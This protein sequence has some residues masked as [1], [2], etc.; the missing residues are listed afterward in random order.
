M[1]LD[2]LRPITW[3]SRK[4][5]DAML[6]SQAENRRYLSGFTGSAGLLLISAGTRP[7]WPPISAT[8]SRW[9]ARL[10][11]FH[12][13]KIQ[14]KVS[15]ICCPELVGRHRASGGWVSRAST[16]PWTSSISGA[17]ATDNVE[18]VPLR[19]RPWRRLR[20]VKDERPS[21]RRLRQ[22]CGVDRCC[23]SPICSEVLDAGHDGGGCSRLG[24]RG[25]HAHP[26]RDQSGL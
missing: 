26:R 22:L 23:L 9:G 3:Q 6:V 1:R 10:L 13:A 15:R 12:L 14:T 19:G 25:L 2:K 20:A 16:S 7:C 11:T 18:W 4:S 17:Q 8:M 24:D 21:S 5:V